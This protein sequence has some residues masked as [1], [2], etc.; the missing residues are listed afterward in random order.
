MR[1]S[2]T[3]FALLLVGTVAAAEEPK[4]VLLVTHAGGFMHDVGAQSPRRILKE[5]GPYNGFQVTCWRFTADPDTPIKV[6]RRVGNQVKDL[7]TTALEEYSYRFQRSMGEPV[8]RQQCGRIDVKSLKEYDAVI[9]LTTSTWDPKSGSH[10]LTESEL[11]DLIAW[12]KGGGAFVAVHCGSDTLHNTPY[13]ELVGTTFGG[14]PWVQKVRLHAEDPK[15]PAAQGLTE[16]SEIFDEISQFGEKPDAPASVPLKIQPY[17]RDRLHIILSV[18]NRS[19][20]ASKGSR[21]DHDYPVAWCQQFGKGRSFYTSLGHHP[22]VWNDRRFQQHFV[23]GLKWAMGQAEGDA[24]PSA[25]AR[26]SPG[27]FAKERSLIGQRRGFRSSRSSL[28]DDS[29]TDLERTNPCI[30]HLDSKY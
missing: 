10:P 4:R 24:T 2:I 18:D 21:P 17:S 3:L 30:Y 28:S 26:S 8:T 13:G 22:A 16:G 20:D 1:H 27:R 11:S 15:H 5:L 25:A 12:V 14:H 6:K 19:F 7:E 9:F 23:G 29:Q